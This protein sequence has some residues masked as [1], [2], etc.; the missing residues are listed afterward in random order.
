MKIIDL[1]LPLFTG[2]PVFPGDPEV[3]IEVIH[4]HQQQTWE[5]RQIKMGS[6]TGTHVDAYAHMHESLENLDQ[7][8]LESFLGKAQVIIDLQNLP[9]KR[10]LLFPQTIDIDYLETILSVS[11]KFVGG[12]LTENLERALLEKRII[13]YT[14]LVH[15][16]KLPV[17]RDFMFY[18]LPL[19]IKNGDGSPVRAIAIIEEL[20]D[21]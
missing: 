11:P 9:E 19:K 12:E 3:E 4:T 18:G 21:R 2:M 16:D 6:H 1:S 5:L 10:G 14:G 7:I 8:P 15:L 17:H 20:E 13:T